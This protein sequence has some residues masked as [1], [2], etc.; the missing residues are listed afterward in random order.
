MNKKKGF[1]FYIEELGF[2]RFAVSSPR[3]SLADL[4]LN[5]SLHIQEIKKAEKEGVN[6]ILFPQLSITG[7]S[8]GSVFKQN[9]LIEKAWETVCSIAEKTSSF[10][11]LSVIGFPFLYRQ[12][13][14]TCSAIIGRGKISAIVPHGPEEF[15]SS[16]FYDFK[17]DPCHISIGGENIP[18]GKHLKFIV[19]YG[20][21]SLNLPSKDFSF[22]FDPDSCSDL[23]LN[24]L[25]QRTRPLFDSTLR[26]RYKTL[27]AEKNSA[28]LFANCGIGEPVS[29]YIFAGECGIYENGKEL[30]F[31]SFV[32]ESILK[33]EPF[34]SKKELYLAADVDISF[35]QSFNRSLSY[36]AADWEILIEKERLQNKKV[37][38]RSVAKNPFLPDC[39]AVHKKFIY[40]NF[41]SELIF[42][43]SA[44]LAR[45]L[46][47]IGCSKCV[48]GI[49]GGLDSSLALLVSAYSLKL[50]DADL[51]NIHAVTMPGFGTTEKTKNNALELAKILGCT[52]LEIP[53]DKALLQHFSDIGQDIK[54]HDIAYENAQARERTQILMDKANQI[55]GIMIG[56]GDLSESALGWM[57]YGGDQMSMYEVNSSIPKTLLKDCIL[58]FADDKIF[59]EDEKKNAAFFEI[60][61]SIINTPVSPE[62]LPPKN[63][64]ISQKTEDIIGPYELHDFFIYHAIGNGFS[65]KKVYF[66]ALE[67][68]KDCA[69]SKT[70]ILKW[71]NIFYKRFFSQQFKRSCCPEGA[72]VTG[73]SLSPRGEW[74]MPSEIS[75]KIWQKELE[76]LVKM[77]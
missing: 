52:V 63:G 56:S 28:V 58:S 48:V 57:T 77:M 19:S 6:L 71:L 59:F 22:S 37:L 1:D 53:I 13:L 54:N 68:F 20:A 51:K 65:P 2:Y 50:L 16:F 38:N 40:K 29:D 24:P 43:Q 11:V 69:Y 15:L 33:K 74:I 25:V 60:L 7:A 41:F 27:S 36:N 66:L 46:Q 76:L 73:F 23:I 72:S 14:Y 5:L 44:S 32:K 35:L 67:A 49:S 30:E 34:S 12:R 75:V 9:L 39:G 21:E 61:S 55:G 62:L 45:R 3:I 18:F 26:Q 4:D 64:E 47:F 10:S 31:T 8:L 70:E 42:L 17:E